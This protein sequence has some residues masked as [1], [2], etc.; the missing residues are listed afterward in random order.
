M[1]VM[2][3]FP[4]SQKCLRSNLTSIC[5]S[6]LFCLFFRWFGIMTRTVVCNDNY[7]ILGNP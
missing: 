1:Y 4:V 6:F 5:E 3:E 2:V 7:G